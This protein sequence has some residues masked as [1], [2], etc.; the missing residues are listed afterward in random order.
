MKTKN[1]SNVLTFTPKIATQMRQF[2]VLNWKSVGF[3]VRFKQKI[4]VK[5]V[6]NSIH[7]FFAFAVFYRKKN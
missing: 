2:G 6:T 1:K 4:S 3:C 7:I 5:G